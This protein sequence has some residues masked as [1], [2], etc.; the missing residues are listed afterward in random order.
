MSHQTPLFAS[1]TNTFSMELMLGSEVQSLEEVDIVVLVYTSQLS[2]R[3]H[4]AS[5]YA[6][7]IAGKTQ[8]EKAYIARTSNSFTLVLTP[9]FLRQLPTGML[10]FSINYTKGRMRVTN[11]IVAEKFI[12]NV[13]QCND[14][15]K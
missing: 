7:W 13:S 5:V 3:L 12:N 4:V 14:A 11:V 8:D 15:V 9:D 10:T 6:D 1:E 2:P